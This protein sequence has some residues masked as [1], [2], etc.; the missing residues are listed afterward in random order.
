MYKK[1]DT[2]SNQ[3]AKQNT[4]WFNRQNESCAENA[5]GKLGQHYHHQKKPISHAVHSIL[6]ECVFFLRFLPSSCNFC[7][8]LYSHFDSFFPSIFSLDICLNGKSI[9]RNEIKYIEC[10]LCIIIICIV[11]VQYEWGSPFSGGVFSLPPSCLFATAFQLCSQAASQPASYAYMRLDDDDDDD[12]CESIGFVSREHISSPFFRLRIYDVR[13]SLSLTL[14][15]ECVFFSIHFVVA[16]AAHLPLLKQTVCVP[17]A[18][19]PSFVS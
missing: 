8:A 10:R 13:E 16:L 11:G 12:S 18:A 9:Y 2:Y 14:L 5:L 4:R 7:S 19:T 6:V 3:W 15:R 17:I 1:R